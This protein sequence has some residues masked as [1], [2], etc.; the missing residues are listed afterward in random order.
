M[1]FSEKPFR[2]I[3]QELST[4]GNEGAKEILDQYDT[5]ILDLLSLHKTLHHEDIFFTHSVSDGSKFLPRMR[6]MTDSR[7]DATEMSERAHCRDSIVSVLSSGTL[8]LKL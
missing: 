4:A 2:N 3:C 5:S 1:D 7:I 8:K 6:I